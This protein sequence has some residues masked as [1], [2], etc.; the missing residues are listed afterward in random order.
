MSTSSTNSSESRIAVITGAGSGIGLNFARKLYY[1]NDFTHMI[2]AV[3]NEK[4]GEETLAAIKDTSAIKISTSSITPST[5]LIPIPCDQNSLVSVV[6]FCKQVKTQFSH[7]DL[8]VLN[9]G[10]ISG[11]AFEK[12]STATIDGFEAVFGINH[13]SHFAIFQ[14]LLPLLQKSS[15]R[16]VPSNYSSTITYTFPRVVLTA[17]HG[18]NFSKVPDN[19]TS[20]PAWKEIATKLGRSGCFEAYCD[21][22]LANVLQCME[23]QHKYGPLI[24]A[25]CLHPG[26]IRETNIWN[27][28]KGIAKF[29]IDGIM[30]P[31][32]KLFGAWQ[33]VDEGGDTILACVEDKEGGKY[34]NVH[35]WEKPSKIG[36]NIEAAHALWKASEELLQEK[37]YDN[38]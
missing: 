5:Q 13:V 21:S 25:N 6:N 28:Q 3:R 36:Q 2:L 27:P 33:T 19:G 23:I 8:L 12:T 26:G 29:L 32:G 22:K 16:T 11:S 37:G 38:M 14:S 34:R 18:H 24:T 31:I 7:I 4:R 9:S 30:F 20:I 35:K 15:P 10:T 17:S 1:R